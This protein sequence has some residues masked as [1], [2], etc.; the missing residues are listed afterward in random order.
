MHVIFV[1]TC[2]GKKLFSRKRE[3]CLESSNLVHVSSEESVECANISPIPSLKKVPSAPVTKNPFLNDFE[4]FPEFPQ[5]GDYDPN[6]SLDETM[7]IATNISDDD[8][9]FLVL[10]APEDDVFGSADVAVAE[11]ALVVDE[12]I[13]S[14]RIHLTELSK[15][16]NVLEALLSSANIL[17]S[18]VKG[19]AVAE[20]FSLKLEVSEHFEKTRKEIYSTSGWQREV[21]LAT[22]TADNE[23]L[24]V[25]FKFSS[26]VDNRAASLRLS[27][28]GMNTSLSDAIIEHL[29]PFALD[30]EKIAKPFY[31][32]VNV[33]DSN[34]LIKDSKGASPLRV[35]VSEVVIE[36]GEE[37]L[38]CDSDG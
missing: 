28:Q 19:A 8:Q 16:V 18:V 9:R 11:E 33:S 13:R 1:F 35:K 20:G 15:N 4:H 7:S 25:K 29:S 34:V 30:E 27:L 14:D 17:L 23:V 5:A 31:L 3:C 22:P 36:Q 37:V 10:E 32:N 21:K 26:A 38:S 6:S 2:N 24:P 12:R